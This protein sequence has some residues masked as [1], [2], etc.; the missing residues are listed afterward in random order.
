MGGGAWVGGSLGFSSPEPPGKGAVLPAA[1]PGGLHWHP[2]ICGLWQVGVSTCSA[3]ETRGV[4]ALALRGWEDRAEPL[5]P[6]GGGRPSGGWETAQ[7][8]NPLVT[9]HP[10]GVLGNKA[11]E[12]LRP[13]LAGSGGDSDVTSPKWPCCRLSWPHARPRG[14]A[15]LLPSQ[16]QNRTGELG[17]QQH[18]LVGGVSWPPCV[19]GS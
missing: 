2:D 4:V 10:G 15:V 11:P 7:V 5:R 19:G 6:G 16:R 12:S 9:Q 17:A 13:W 14:N 1:V 3:P 8:P 18:S